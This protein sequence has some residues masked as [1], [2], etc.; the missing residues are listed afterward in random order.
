MNLRAVFRGAGAAG[1][2]ALSGC[3]Y[4]DH[5]APVTRTVHHD[6]YRDDHHEPVYRDRHHYEPPPHHDDDY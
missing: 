4:P 3:V 1:V 6:V 2:L 5:H